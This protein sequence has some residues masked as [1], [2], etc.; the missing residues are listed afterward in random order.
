MPYENEP[1]AV[2]ALKRA[3]Q[4]LSRSLKRCQ[5]IVD[6]CRDKLEA[7]GEASFLLGSK[8]RLR[9]SQPPTH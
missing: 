3:N 9:G 1:A 8:S 7:Q 4:D 6:E 2:A 5:A